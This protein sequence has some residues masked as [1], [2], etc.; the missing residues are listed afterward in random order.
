MLAT[1]LTSKDLQTPVELA[2]QSSRE[3]EN[4]YVEKTMAGLPSD[5]IVRDNARVDM[6]RSTKSHESRGRRCWSRGDG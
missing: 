6:A 5:R 3:R 4:E 2:G 1:P